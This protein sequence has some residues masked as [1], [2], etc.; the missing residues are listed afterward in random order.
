MSSLEKGLQ[1]LDLLNPNRPVLRVGE[2]SKDL[3]MPKATVSRL[4][5]SLAEAQFLEREFEAGAY[6]VGV[7]PISL[8]RLYFEREGLL[9]LV[10]EAVSR[11]VDKFGFTGHAGIVLG[12]DRI[13]LVARHG[14]YA[15]QHAAKI[16]DRSFALK[17]IIGHTVLARKPD[18]EVLAQLGFSA[19]VTEIRGFDK[20]QVLSI[21]NKARETPV[22]LTEN[23]LTPGVSS[24]GTAVSDPVAQDIIGFCVSFP[25]FAADESMRQTIMQE[26]EILAR[27]IGER[28]QDVNW[29]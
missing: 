26:V 18:A 13:L 6:R 9:N 8:S 25:A 21:L 19:S 17:T 10:A 24:I 4:L 28:V 2:V 20:D 16:A 29:R 12:T 15:M 22:I 5:K 7:K 14:S 1:I 11:L 27:D 23:L 3:G